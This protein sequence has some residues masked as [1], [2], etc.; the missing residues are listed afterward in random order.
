MRRLKGRPKPIALTH[1]ENIELTTTLISYYEREVKPYVPEAWIDRSKTKVGMTF[2]SRKLLQ[3]VPPRSL[4]TL[5][6]S[7]AVTAEIVAA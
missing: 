6:R 2:H 1:T 4:T 5:I 3:L 7:G